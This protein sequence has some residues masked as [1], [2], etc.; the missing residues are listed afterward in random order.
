MDNYFC[1]AWKINECESQ[2]FWRE[3]LQMNRIRRNTLKLKQDQTHLIKMFV[4]EIVAL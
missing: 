3:D 2:H 1:Y 4:Q